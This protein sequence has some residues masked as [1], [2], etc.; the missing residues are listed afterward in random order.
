MWAMK[1]GTFLAVKAEIRKAIKKEHGDTVKLVLFLDEPQMVIPADF[2]EC[3]R[4]E[5]KLLQLFES[6]PE[7]QK[8]EITDWI[9]SAKTEDEKITRMA[10]TLEKLENSRITLR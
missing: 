9:F 6:Y 8:K 10:K 4:E 1:K 3:L 7:K 2:L 5:P